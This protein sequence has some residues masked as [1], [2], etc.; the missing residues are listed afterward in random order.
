VVQD[1]SPVYPLTSKLALFKKFRKSLLEFLD[2]LVA[3]AAETG[4]LY[5]TEMLEALRQWAAAMS[6]SQLRSF[7]HTATVVALQTQTALCDVASGVE[8]EAEIIARQVEGDKKRSG[9]A[10]GKATTARQK[11]LQKREAE[12]REKREFL[13]DALNDLTSV[14]VRYLHPARH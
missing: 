7:R 14:C 4:A 5:S 11:E 3:S 1:D 12:V 2:R 9:G 6:S 13:A 10:K 8:K